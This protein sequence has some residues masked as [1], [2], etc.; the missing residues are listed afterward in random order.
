MRNLLLNNKICL[1]QFNTASAVWLKPHIIDFINNTGLT[2]VLDPFVGNGDILHAVA[3][4]CIVKRFAGVDIDPTKGYSVADSLIN[5]PHSNNI[6]VTNPPYLAK[7]SAKQ[8]KLITTY[9]YFDNYS[10]LYLVALNKCLDTHDYVVAIVPETFIL[11]GLFLDRLYSYTVIEEQL[12]NDTDCPVCVVC[13]T[14]YPVKDTLVYKNNKYV[15]KL[16]TLNGRRKYPKHKYTITFNVPNGNIGLHGVDGIRNNKIHFCSP[17]DLNYDITN[18]KPSSRTIT[19]IKLEH[20]QNIIDII[21]NAN[22]ILTKYRKQTHD[23]WLAAFKGNTKL[24][25]RRRRLDF[26][27]ARAIL[28]E[29]IDV[30]LLH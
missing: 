4:A 23:I 19:I 8:K 18:I 17:C 24:G 10:D 5:I 27:T 9:K 16:S 30:S 3:N 14:K 6:I 1:G 29:A 28:E 2:G 11:T 20:Q 15:A 12:F 13:F 7:N 26:S 22:I 25:N 21:N